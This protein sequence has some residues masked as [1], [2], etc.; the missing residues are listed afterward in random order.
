MIPVYNLL[1]V[2]INSMPIKKFLKKSKLF[3]FMKTHG[4][5]A[6]RKVRDIEEEYQVIDTKNETTKN[7][8]QHKMLKLSIYTFVKTLKK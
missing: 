7:T 6:M 2:M 5:K 8:V 3:F 1:R 4:N